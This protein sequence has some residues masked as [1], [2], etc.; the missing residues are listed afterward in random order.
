MA[1]ERTTESII[2]K[3]FDLNNSK[4]KDDINFG[5]QGNVE[6]NYLQKLLKTIPGKP[7]EENLDLIIKNE[8]GSHGKPEFVITNRNFPNLVIVVEAKVDKKNH[9]TKERNKPKNYAVD[10]ALYYS[11]HL[12]KEN[13]VISIAVSGDNENNLMVNTFYQKHENQKLSPINKFFKDVKNIDSYFKW[14]KNHKDYEE[15]PRETIRKL[16]IKFHDDL[17]ILGFTEKQKPLFICN[18]L[19]SLKDKTFRNNFHKYGTF[20]EF[21]G[22]IKEALKRVLEDSEIKGESK[23]LLRHQ[24]DKD[25]TNKKLQKETNQGGIGLNYFLTELDRKIRTLIDKEFAFDVMGE[26]YHEF[27]KYSGGDGKGLGIVLTPYHISELFIDLLDKKGW[28]NENSSIIDIAAGTGSFLVA[29]MTHLF[30][31]YPNNK[32]KIKSNQITGI[33]INQDMHL[34]AIANMIF[35]H[36]GKTHIFQEDA[37]NFHGNNKV[38]TQLKENQPNIG[39]MNPP[40]AQGGKETELNFTL[41]LLELL[42]PGGYAITIVPLSCAIGTKFKTERKELFNKH[43]L[44]AV[45]TMPEDLFYPTASTNTCVMIW[46]AKIP[47]DSKKQT[48]F[49]ILKD[50]GFKKD[51]KLGRLDKE[52]KWGTIKSDFLDLWMEEI[53]K[54]GVSIKKSVT[55]EDEW[56]AEAYVKTDYSKLKQED[57][58]KN[59]KDYMAFKI[60]FGDLNE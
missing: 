20:E 29:G 42:Q 11:K 7:T 52:N 17:R 5:Y 40:Y 46:Q 56:L 35:N 31:K 45:I 10:G 25:L 47:H 43:T 30:Q 27:I 51:K 57:F 36:D 6:N 2:E 49:G 22:P 55:W 59:L 8:K 37:L 60:K 58:I 3:I 44:K 26:F 23:N 4:Y 24:L 41:K 50:D 53:E 15:V 18:L 21:N 1:N 12:A 14:F 19:L 9:E 48:W 28:V 33:E 54:P 16:A 32:N 39:M 13:N 38:A 34:M